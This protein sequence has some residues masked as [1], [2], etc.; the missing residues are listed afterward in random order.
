MMAT[1]PDLYAELRK[2]C[3]MI[4]GGDDFDRWTALLTKIDGEEP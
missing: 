4:G 1:S 3:Q 2:A